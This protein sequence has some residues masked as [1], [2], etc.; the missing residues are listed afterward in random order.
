MKSMIPSALAAS[1]MVALLA[2]GAVALQPANIKKVTLN[3][4]EITLDSRSGAILQL[5]YPGPG[6]LL[7]ADAAEAGLVDV[8]YPIEEFEPLRLAARHARDAVIE[9]HP[10]RVVIRVA[11]LGPSRA[12]FPSEGDVAATVTLQADADG[13]SL[14]LACEIENR[15]ARAVRQVIFPEL[16]GLMPV[17]GAD[18][19]VLKSCGFASAPFRE[20]VVPEVD[21]WYAENSSTV[22]YTSGGMFSKMW[23]RWLDLGGLNGGLSLFPQRW[24]WEAH[25]TTVVQLRQTTGRLRILCAHASEIKPGE[26]WSSG[27]WVLTPHRSGWAKGIEPYRQWVRSK[28]NQRYAMPRHIREGLGFRTVWMCQNQPNDPADVV[29]RFS[30]LPALAEE[31]K[32]HGL[33]EMVMWTWQPG[34]DASLPAPHAHLGTEQ[35]LLAA[36]AQCR[37][38]GVNLAPF[39]SVLQASPK[40]AG[41][42]GLKIPDNNGWTYHTEMIPRWN[43]PYATGLSCVQVGPSHALWQDEVTASCRRWADKGICSFSWD[44]YMTTAQQPSIQDLTSRIRDYARALDPESTFS[45]EELWNLEVDCEWLDYTW[46]W[47]GYRDVQAFTNAFPAPRRNANINRSVREARFSFMD[48]LMLNV[49][50]AKPDNINGS[51]RIVNVPELSHTLKTCA[52][53]RKQFLPYFTDG[54]LIGNC[55]LNEVHPHARVSAYVLP[56][57]VLAIVLNQGSEGALSF[58]YDLEPWLPGHTSFAATQFDEAGAEVS[59]GDLSRSGTYETRPLRPVEMTVV[60]FV[61][62]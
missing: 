29:W 4:L 10:D 8:A 18:H 13:R 1:M 49:W 53:L 9:E 22:E 62:K 2:T 54:V 5:D 38:L 51:E 30:D 25:T 27:N 47:G 55:V 56:D 58:S 57:R 26:K 15:S 21:Q 36:V 31:A 12:N 6:R 41:R 19:T 35:D 7:E 11:R 3:G 16:R 61:A 40:T 34:F 24:G 39:I 43:P 20:L 23:G 28:V 48:N 60:E 50:P 52:A 44:Q 37:T 46:N 33:L 32:A 59:T 14:V 45:G 17:A 42:Y